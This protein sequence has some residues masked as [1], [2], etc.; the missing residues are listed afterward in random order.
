MTLIEVMV[1]LVVFTISVYLMSSTITASS[2]HTQIKRERALAVEMAR[3]ELEILRGADFVDLFAS[4]NHA[5]EDDPDGAG[6]A[7]GPYFAVPGLDPQD[8]DP[9]GF[10]GEIVLPAEG[11]VLRED[12][13]MEE[14]G[15]PRDL[16]GDFLIDAADHAGDYLIL[17][18]LVRVE[19]NGRAGDRLFQM[20]T[21]L[22]KLLK[23]ES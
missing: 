3:N 12:A 13:E 22:A 20:Y 19:W 8:D 6:T 2:V 10:V 17:P 1:A 7:P 9:D 4:Y 23:A 11:S 14:L 5:P 21:M 15:L 16:D 18:V